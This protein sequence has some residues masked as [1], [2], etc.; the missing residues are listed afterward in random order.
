MH[1]STFLSLPAGR[2]ARAALV[3]AGLALAAAAVAPA[4]ASAAPTPVLS[5]SRGG[6]P[7]TSFDFGT[8][9]GSPGEVVHFVLTNTSG[10]ASSALR[11]TVTGS[12]AFSKADDSCTGTSLKPGGFCVV[13]IG[14]FPTTP[15]QTYSGIVTARPASQDRP[16]ASLT[17]Q[18]ATA[19]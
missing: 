10:S 12:T 6:P 8:L 13:G 11:I 14:F 1:R 9:V 5:W 17:L 16:A 15:G 7:I 18:G 4:A 2:L 19:S 3:A